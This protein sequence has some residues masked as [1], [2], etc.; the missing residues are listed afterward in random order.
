METELGQ[1]TIALDHCMEV[2]DE[3]GQV[4][5]SEFLLR[6]GSGTVRLRKTHH[7]IDA[8]H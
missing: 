8:D 1:A 5:T 6:D 4:V 3:D 7:R 2:R